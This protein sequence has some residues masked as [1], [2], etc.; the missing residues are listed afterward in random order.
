MAIDIPSVVTLQKSASADL[1]SPGDQPEKFSFSPDYGSYNPYP[2]VDVYHSSYCHSAMTTLG[3]PDYLPSGNLV[4]KEDSMIGE[5]A[6]I[7][8][9][10]PCHNYSLLS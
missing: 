9:I 3:V 8:Q 7:H 1:V 10:V 5:K 4:E 6:F 2:S